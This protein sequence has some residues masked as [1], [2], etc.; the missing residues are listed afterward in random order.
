M[1]LTFGVP[2][3]AMKA[4]LTDLGATETAENLLVADGWQ[5]AVKKSESV[6]IGSL[7][8]GRIEVEF[9]GDETAI[10]AMLEKLHWKTLRGGG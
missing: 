8:V 2:L 3:W 1:K 4:Y 9:S 5:A 10:A 6:K 7:V